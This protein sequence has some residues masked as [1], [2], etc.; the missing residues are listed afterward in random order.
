MIKQS[1]AQL[2]NKLDSMKRDKQAV[3]IG[4]QGYE[5]KYNN[6][7]NRGRDYWLR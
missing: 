5:S 1:L 4:I 3:E 2:R 7:G 6:N